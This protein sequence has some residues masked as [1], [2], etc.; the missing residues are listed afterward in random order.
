VD[1]VT[2]L[3]SIDPFDLLVLVYLFA[4]F[5]LG[6]IQGAI[7]RLLGLA[8][9]VFSF[10]AALYARDPVGGFLAANWTDLPRDY[11]FMFAF[12]LVFVVLGVAFS[13]LIQ[14]SYRRAPLFERATVADEL[15]GGLL[16]ILQGAILLG[17]GIVI[18]DSFYRLPGSGPFRGELG[19]LRTVYQLYDPSATAH[20]YREAIIPAAFGL[21]D[22]II[23]NAVRALFPGS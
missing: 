17:A 8:S 16:G 1:L 5:L 23:P 21:L 10:F 4:F 19:I 20:L 13:V 6:Y 2:S 14:G 15:L 7:R 22:G 18:L 12:G 11:T 9:I 3:R